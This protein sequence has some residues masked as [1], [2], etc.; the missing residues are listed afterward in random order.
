VNLLAN[1][2]TVLVPGST[3][4]QATASD[5][6]GVTKVEF[7]R[8]ATLL[9]TSTAA[10]FQTTVG[11]TAADLGTVAFTAKAFDAQNNSTTSTVVNVLVTTPSSGDTYAS[12]SGVDVGNTTCSQAN[13]CR[14]IAQAAATAQANKTVWLMNGD[15]TAVTQPVPIAIPAG[16]TLRALTPGLAGVGQQI[17][18]QGSATV[19]GVVLRR[20]GF[21]DWGSIAASSGTVTLDGVKAVG[22]SAS[23]GGFPAVLALAGSVHATMTPGNIADYAD[24][25]TPAD[26]GVAIYATLAGNAWLT[27][28]GGLF[29]G[30]KLGGAD[31]LYGGYNRGA[32][33]LV[34]SSR[35]DLNNVVLNV[36]SGGIFM[37]GEAT[38]LFMSG[39]TL[40]AAGNV[41]PGYG[42][43]AAKGTPQISLVNS[44]VS[45]FDRASVGLYVGTSAQ[46]G[47]QATVTASNATLTGNN[48]GAYVIP[49]ATASSLTI[50]GSTVGFVGNTHGG[51]V[52]LDACNVDLAGADLSDNATDSTVDTGFTFYGGVW[53]GLPNKT[54]Q[55]KL[56]NAQIVDNKSSAGNN[57]NASDNSGV[58]MAGNASSVFDL[59]TAASP[60]NNLIQGNT[61][62]A[63]TSGLNVGVAAGVTVNAV[64]NTFAPNVQ[65]ANAQGRYQ[66]GTAPCSAASCNLTTGAG[67]NYRITSGTLRLA[68]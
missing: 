21:G 63:Q 25:L 7:W 61:S 23:G 15:Y 39:S 66:L 59:G 40:H 36:E 43:Y 67:P 18:L 42:I 31:A 27:V 33:N 47:V 49:G 38:Q 50:T 32:F 4:L 8:G 35:L 52:C 17:A 19:V 46:P 68:Q 22:N 64:G 54:Y 58:T 65:G 34:G 20:V 12:P 26:Q 6:I 51:I 13:P 41:G 62:S 55:L 16:L 28:N 11:F 2:A 30:A 1:P 24:Q 5:N 57:A 9:A 29:G 45:G 44:V 48:L 37:Y 53:M 60:G 14:S 3:T 56:R 10:P